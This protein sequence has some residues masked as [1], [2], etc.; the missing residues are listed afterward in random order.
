M[1][2]TRIAA[3]PNHFFR[4]DVLAGL[5]HARKR[6]PA[7]YFY[8]T[9]GSRLFDAIT[10]LPEYYLTRTELSI[11]RE[12]AA[13]MAARCGPRRLLIE[14]GAGSLSKVRL[15][16][17]ELQQPAGYAP[18]DVSGDHLRTASAALAKDYPA[19]DVRPV[20]ADFTVAF[21]LPAAPADGRIIFFPGSTLGNLHP[22]EADALF[23]RIATLVGPGGGLL[24]GVDL[25]KSVDVLERAYN[26]AAGV[27]AAFN[28][29]LLVRINR[30]L[31]ADFDS[32]AFRHHAFFNRE[33]SRIE[34]HL[35]SERRQRV[36]VGPVVFDFRAG[37]SIHTEN[38]YKYDLGKLRATY[39]NHAKRLRANQPVPAIQLGNRRP[40]TPPQPQSG[41][42]DLLRESFGKLGNG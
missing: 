30:E 31:Q 10:E 39:F 8:D 32:A 16:L 34:M 41:L 33:R 37:E 36:R 26:D 5:S 3:C 14:F 24:L 29:N 13:A 15:L 19:L 21:E 1:T 11:L 12:H 9:A 17:D 22:P 25:Q 2:N 42:L 20:V 6:L 35:V 18:L 27:T 7:K 4:A 23:R 38:S 40:P 28:R